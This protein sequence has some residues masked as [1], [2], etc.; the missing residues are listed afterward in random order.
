MKITQTEILYSR[1]LAI[2]DSDNKQMLASRADKTLRNRRRLSTRKWFV[3][4]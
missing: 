3:F 2:S 1:S 4:L